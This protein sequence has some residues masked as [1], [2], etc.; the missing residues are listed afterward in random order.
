[1]NVLLV[2]VGLYI[3]LQ[4]AIGVWVSRWIK[5]E[6]DY[7]VAGRSLGVVLASFSVFATW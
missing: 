1:M 7:L 6:A 2:G 3:A 4:F 5:T